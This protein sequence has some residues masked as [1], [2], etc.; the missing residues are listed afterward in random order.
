MESVRTGDISCRFESEEAV[1]DSALAI[2]P[3]ARVLLRWVRIEIQHFQE[4][5]GGAEHGPFVAENVVVR[6]DGSTSVGTGDLTA[7]IVIEVG[8]GAWLLPRGL[9]LSM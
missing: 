1:V 9:A 5:G 2:N 8:A 7:V 3:L 4:V 6:H